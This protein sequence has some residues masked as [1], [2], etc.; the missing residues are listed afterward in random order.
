[1]F[2]VVLSLAVLLL[3]YAAHAQEMQRPRVS[4]SK[5]DWDAAAASFPGKGD[6]DTAALFAKLNELNAPRFPGIAQSPVPMLLPFDAAALQDNKKAETVPGGFRPSKFF[7]PGPAGYHATFFTSATD[8]GGV[9]YR[10]PIEVQISG[11]RFVYEL[12]GPNINEMP[13]TTPKDLEE[14]PGIRR[15]LREAHVRYAF[16]KF[17]VPYVVSVQCFD[18]RV[19]AKRLA[20]KDADLVAVRFLKTLN[21]AGGTPQPDAERPQPELTRPQVVSQSFTYVAPGNLIDNSG[22]KEFGGRADRTVYSLIRFPIADAPAY[23]KSQSFNP[24]GDCYMTGRVGRPNKKGAS[25]RCRRNDKPLVFDE[26]ATENFS[27]PWRD[28]FCETRD[29]QV[30]QC[31]GGIGHQGQDIRP[32]SCVLK[33]SGADR[34]EPYQHDVVAVHDGMILR[35][36]AN[37]VIHE[38]AYIVVNTAT[39]NV[40]F[41]YMHMDPKQMDDAGLVSG[42]QIRQGEVLGKVGNF[43]KKERGTSYHLH[44][45]A[46]AFTR[47]GWV[48]VNPYMTLVSAYERLIGARGTEIAEGNPV[49]AAT[50]AEPPTTVA[51]VT[52]AEPSTLHDLHGEP[53]A[54]K[55]KP[56]RKKRRGNH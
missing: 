12:D 9:R 21:I 5:V 29:T 20:C 24:W 48:W 26:A 35:N 52:K 51:S 50:P 28:N 7:L 56:A 1:M 36:P 10:Q 45:D 6:L 2:R 46:Q 31:P 16:E 17:G 25:Y 41:R 19:T 14:F 42:R 37:Y 27:Y 44:F 8:I 11:A 39:D 30:G 23:A 53:R 3:S 55:V 18:G 32:S 4:I 47:D 43:Y 15:I 54:R 49:A 34:C 13:T 33:N 22:Y 40:R 38:T